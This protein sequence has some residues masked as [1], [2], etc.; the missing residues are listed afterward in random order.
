MSKA[1]PAG[2]TPG[3]IR[4]PSGKLP[5]KCVILRVYPGPIRD[6]SGNLRDPAGK[7][8]VLQ[9]GPGRE[10]SGT[11][12]GKSLQ[13]APGAIR[14]IKYRRFPIREK[15]AT[16][17]GKLPVRSKYPVK[18]FNSIRYDFPRSGTSLQV[19]PVKFSLSG[20][21]VHADEM[22]V[23]PVRDSSL[24]GKCFVS[25]AAPGLSGNLR[26]Y[27]GSCR[28]KSLFRTGLARP[29]TVVTLQLT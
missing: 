15:F 9:P 1:R 6:L 26:E 8:L 5:G 3:P 24:S 14:E 2:T 17:S 27:P 7:C 25:G 18:V 29:C 4:D 28:E 11:T 23:Y 12:S 20:N 13:T 21:N 19:Y 22:Q 16:L 10:L